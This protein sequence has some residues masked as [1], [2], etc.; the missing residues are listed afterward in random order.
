MGISDPKFTP[1]LTGAE[2]GLTMPKQGMNEEFFLTLYET[3]YP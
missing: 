2:R 3:M 1:P